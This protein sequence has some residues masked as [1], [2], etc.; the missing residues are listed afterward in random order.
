[1]MGHPTKKTSTAAAAAT[2]PLPLLPHPRRLPFLRRPLLLPLVLVLV[3]HVGVLPLFPRAVNVL[4]RKEL[5]LDF[6]NRLPIA[7]HPEA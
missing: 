4:R 1:M 2:P 7:H 5:R 3:L 6:R